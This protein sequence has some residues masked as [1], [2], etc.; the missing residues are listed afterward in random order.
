MTGVVA[1]FT[2]LPSSGKSTLAAAV[3]VELREHGIVPV[4]LDSDHLRAALVPPPGYDQE[5]RAN[6]YATLARLAALVARQG[7][8]VLVSATAHLR[9]FRDDARRLSPQFVEIFVDTPLE[10]CRRRDTK[11]LYAANI[12]AV[13]GV[14]VTYEPPLSPDFTVTPSDDAAAQI[15][16]QLVAL[17][18]S[19]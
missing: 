2:G 7:H 15:A 4:L 1:W 16:N 10:E 9:A 5:S 8:V 14:G 13:P 3:V 12:A 18:H 6:F 19:S 11:G 17:R